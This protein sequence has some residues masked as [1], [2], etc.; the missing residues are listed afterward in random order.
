[1]A[2]VVQSIA[3]GAKGLGQNS[4]KVHNEAESPKEFLSPSV[5]GKK[6]IA[7]NRASLSSDKNLVVKPVGLELPPPAMA[8]FLDNRG[9]NLNPSFNFKA[10]SSGQSVGKGLKKGQMA[11][12]TDMEV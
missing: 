8:S 7:K 11:M 12:Q 3:K 5:R 10:I 2:K 1:M 9:F 6:G 4:G